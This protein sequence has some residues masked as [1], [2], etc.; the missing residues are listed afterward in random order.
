MEYTH[1]NRLGR[2]TRFS[3]VRFL[4]G[5]LF[6]ALIFLA[7]KSVI[8]NFSTSNSSSAGVETK[9]SQAQSL[10]QLE[11]EIKTLIETQNG[12]WSVYLLDLNDA[13]KRIGI[14]ENVIHRA[15]SVNKLYVLASL[16]YLAAKEEIDLD[17]TVT[18][19]KGDIQD[20]GTGTIRY[21][22]PGTVYSLKTLARLLIE[23]SDN[24][25][26]YILRARMGDEEIQ[27]LVD[28]FDF[29]QTSIADNKTSLSDVQALFKKIANEEIT[30][31]AYTQEMMDFLNQTDFEDRLPT[32]LPK[33][34]DVYHKIGNEVGNIHD[35]GMVIK[36]NKKYFLGI[37]TSDI[38]DTE[39]EAKKTIAQISKIV[40]D[41]E[42]GNK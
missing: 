42:Y 7:I 5:V 10:S 11:L 13:Q 6:L 39:E 22:S 15:A 17:E 38:G 21:D 20:Y 23:K 12:S 41:F 1:S 2:K 32:L 33:D 35:V 18:L 37:M 30:N 31:K 34:V 9:K 25:A 29:N 14:N 19:S 26:E 40:Y 27:S 3:A 28:E 16:Y 24:T 8:P 4:A 36:D